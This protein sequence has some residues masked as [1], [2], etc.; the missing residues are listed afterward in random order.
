MHGEDELLEENS[1]SSKWYLSNC[2][3]VLIMLILLYFTCTPF[4]LL[5]P[6]V[7]CKGHRSPEGGEGE[8]RGA[9]GRAD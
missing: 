4:Y 1:E 6:F 7:G 5:I 2:I 8:T 9:R 3:I